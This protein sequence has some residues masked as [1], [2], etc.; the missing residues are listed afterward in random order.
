MTE[1]TIFDYTLELECN[2]H[3]NESH[4]EEFLRQYDLSLDDIGEYIEEPLT[5]EKFQDTYVTRFYDDGS[6]NFELVLCANE[7]EGLKPFKRAV[8]E[9]YSKLKW[10][11]DENVGA[12]ISIKRSKFNGQRLYD[13]ERAILLTYSLLEMLVLAYNPFL[14]KEKEKELGDKK[15]FFNHQAL[16]QRNSRFA[17][18]SIPLRN[19]A[20]FKRKYNEDSEYTAILMNKEVH[21]EKF[22]EFRLAN[23]KKLMFLTFYLQKIPN[24]FNICD[25][26]E[27]C[28]CLFIDE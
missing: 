3:N 16:I 12:H 1:K 8:R 5:S 15:H 6:V 14:D 7:G 2:T 9:F 21:G 26:I 27:L 17:R 24:W 19:T 25:D 13:H 23:P 20:N 11:F 28:I 22:I 10:R 4:L 18:V